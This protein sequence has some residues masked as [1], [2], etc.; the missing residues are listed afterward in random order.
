VRLGSDMHF[1]PA[2]IAGARE[3]LVAYLAERGS[4]PTSELRDVIGVSRK[5]AIPLLE[6]FDASGLTRFEGD[7]R[8]L[9]KT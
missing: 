6:H 3:R 5:Y 7:E 1:D 9:R 4:A 2:V 8:S